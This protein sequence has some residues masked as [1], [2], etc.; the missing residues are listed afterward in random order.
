MENQRF[1][2][3]TRDLVV[4]HQGRHNR[5]IPGLNRHVSPSPL[6]PTV[7]VVTIPV[8]KTIFIPFSLHP[9]QHTLARHGSDRVVRTG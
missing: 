7:L 4:Y 3:R 5:V 9:V 2:D 8:S 6:P 1:H